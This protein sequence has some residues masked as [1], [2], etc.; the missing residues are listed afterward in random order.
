MT[1]LV[2]LGGAGRFLKW[3]VVAAA[4]VVGT[5]IVAISAA[6]VAGANP[7]PP[8]GGHHVLF[9]SST[10]A[11]PN[12]G[13]SCSTAG[14]SSIQSA[15]DAAPPGGTVFVCAG[16]YAEQV[17]ISTSN[18]TIE[19]TGAGSVIQPNSTSPATP[20]TTTDPDTGN[21]VVPI[22][23]VEPGVN[24]VNIADL[25]IDGSALSPTFEGCG[26]DFEGLRF[27]SASGRVQSV[28]VEN[29]V[30]PNGLGGCQ[31][32]N[33]V[34]VETSAGGR[35]NVDFRNDTIT[36]YDKNGL[37][38][39]DTGTNCQIHD[40]SVTGTGANGAGAENGIQVG[41]GAQGNVQDD[42]ISANDWTGQTNTTEPEADFAAGVLL[43][44]AAD[45]TNV[46]NNTLTDDQIGV[47]VVHSDA[48][49][50]R[51]TISESSPGIANSIGVFAVPCDFYC[52]YF[53]LSGGD[54]RVNVTNNTIS[55]PASPTPGT[56]GISIGD[57][58]ASST[59]SVQMN[60]NNN[61]I[62]GAE[63]NVETGP[64]AFGHVS[65]DQA[66]PGP[67]H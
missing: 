3:A 22:V 17:S 55:F 54:I 39:N 57:E 66:P 8:A 59:G 19:G 67:R 6:N 64:T 46:Q 50:D 42:T 38:C 21:T 4:V 25:T 58:A 34:V 28:T 51:N 37:T 36:G 45:N 44:G 43:Y 15:V 1:G 27:D 24:N 9:V 40:V 65:T 7:P 48:N 63:S 47:E 16:T 23:S 14:Y 32:G 2:F 20:S 18:L 52:S 10:G 26:E 60:V 35:S 29:I 12:T 30:L 61:A 11:S 5:T 49:L 56:V 13:T 33:A 31:E 62:S 41:F 53:N